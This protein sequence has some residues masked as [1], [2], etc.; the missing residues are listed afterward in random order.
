[1]TV[2]IQSSS[3]DAALSRTF[4]YTNPDTYS[5]EEHAKTLNPVVEELL[6]KGPIAVENS[7]LEP[8]S[9]GVRL[10]LVCAK[11][12][13]VTPR[14]GAEP[15]RVLQESGQP[16]QSNFT[17]HVSQL[18]SLSESVSDIT[19]IDAL[20]RSHTFYRRDLP[21]DAG[22]VITD[23][24]SE[25]VL[26]SGKPL[27]LSPLYEAK[28]KKP[29]QTLDILDKRQIAIAKKTLKMPD[30]LDGLVGPTKAEARSILKK[31]GISFKESQLHSDLGYN[32]DRMGNVTIFDRASGKD[33]FVQGEEGS[34][35]ADELENAPDDQTVQMIL[36]QYSHV[37]ESKKK[38]RKGLAEAQS[39]QQ[40]FSSVNDFVSAQLG[41]D[42]RDLPDR[43]YHD[44][45]DDGISPREAARM[46]VDEEGG[47]FGFGFDES[48]TS[49]P[50]SEIHIDIDD[51]E[52]EMWVNND[53]GLY[54]LQQNSELSVEDF[55]EQNRDLID[56]VIRTAVE[57]KR[58]TKRTRSLSEDIAAF[59]GE[60]ADFIGAAHKLL[61]SSEVD[62]AHRNQEG[63]GYR[64]Y[65]RQVV[66][67]RDPSYLLQSENQEIK[68]GAVKARKDLIDLA[69]TM[70]VESRCSLKETSNR[71]WTGYDSVSAI[72][73]YED[74]T[75]NGKE[76][77]E[78]F[79]YLVDTG[80]AWRLQGSYGRMATSL[81][82]RG[83]LEG[84]AV[85]RSSSG[86]LT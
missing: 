20:G 10:T 77:I 54:N 25:S 6:R 44:W 76:T 43:P 16:A 36:D 21:K 7:C 23:G 30:A 72:M 27:D 82:N 73:A 56:Q 70:T 80:L 55:I 15:N 14:K 74:G 57:S 41:V 51:N 81:I 17:Q 63:L 35:L 9:R 24:L 18:F 13:S 5:P 2:S 22:V 37:L 28:G 26:G 62:P 33:V 69:G 64:A 46:V 31:F 60:R 29:K 58:R 49:T 40:W 50:L 75:L 1:M 32:V 45:Y 86:P 71:D 38:S 8:H 83:L 48:K 59:I 52:R 12:F 34:Q 85:S 3:P 42:V 79:Q 4:G 53:E 84:S 47:P 39:F 66:T 67:K 19:V 78:L 68:L 61:S 65:L 11:T